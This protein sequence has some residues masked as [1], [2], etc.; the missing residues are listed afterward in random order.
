MIIDA[1]THVFPDAIAAKSIAFLEATGGQ[2]AR[3]DGTL[4]GLLSSS[5]RAGVDLSLVLPV[6]TR[7]KQYDSINRFALELD[8][9]PG[10]RA[11]AGMHPAL[12]NIEER[13][14]EIAAQG[15]KGVKL[16][17]DY[18]QTDIDDPGYVRILE[19]CRK[20]GLTAVIHAGLDPAFP[21]HVHCPPEKSGE[22]VRALTGNGKPFIV[23]AHLGGAERLDAVEKYLAG[24][25]VYLDLSFILETLDPAYLVSFARAH[26]CD[27][28][29]FGTDSPW[30]DPGEY[31]K[32]FDRAAFTA[33]EK[34][35]ILGENCLRLL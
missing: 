10:V 4:A 20:R 30:R 2:H 26:G 14:D 24:L 19:G 31:L 12:E 7:P 8:R 35:M 21:D 16:H 3:T 1:H 23:L 25:P 5:R 28:I 29:L 27:R 34:R 17:P 15:F 22:L 33:D 11:F 18:Q 32:L 13:L 6:V 9:T